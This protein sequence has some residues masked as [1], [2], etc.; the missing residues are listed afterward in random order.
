MENG[1]GL[2]MYFLLKMGI[3]HCYVSLPEGNRINQLEKHP[4]FSHVGLGFVCFLYFFRQISPD[5]KP[6]KK[7]QQFCNAKE[8]IANLKIKWLLFGKIYFP[9]YP[10]VWWDCGVFHPLLEKLN[11]LFS[12]IL[13][14]QVVAVRLMYFC[15]VN[16]GASSQSIW[17]K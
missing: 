8:S 12:E 7:K 17:A 4:D 3:F 6:R 1:P 2:K 14:L 5:E 10:R 15:V 11:N 9:Q 13:V 16:F